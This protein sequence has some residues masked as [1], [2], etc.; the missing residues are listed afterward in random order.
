MILSVRFK[1]SLHFISIDWLLGM[2][3]YHYLFELPLCSD[4]C[5]SCVTW[6]YS[7]CTE[8]HKGGTKLHKEK[9]VY[10]IM[11]EKS[12]NLKSDIKIRFSQKKELYLCNHEIK[13]HR[14]H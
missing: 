11:S 10:S 5:Q 1:Y 2:L 7:Y 8:Y 13:W 9:D 3:K 4:S 14:K 6:C 12:H